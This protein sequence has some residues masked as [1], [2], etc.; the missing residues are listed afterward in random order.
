M[1]GGA[2]LCHKVFVFDRYLHEAISDQN[3]RPTL[4]F[5]VERS[6]LNFL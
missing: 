2:A 6:E 3:I 4:Q 5:A 1:L